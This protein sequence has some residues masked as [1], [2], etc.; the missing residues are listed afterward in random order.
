MKFT[1]KALVLL[2]AIPLLSAGFLTA[3]SGDD[4]TEVETITITWEIPDHA[5][6]TVEGYD[7][8]PTEV[9]SGTSLTFSVTCDSGYEV[10]SVTN[11]NKKVTASNGSY[12][13]TFSSSTTIAIN[14]S[15]VVSNIEVTS[16][17]T[18]LSYFSGESLDTTGMV[19][20]ATYADG[21][22][23]TIEKGSSGYA[24]SPS[25]FEGGE[26]SFSV[27]YNSFTIEVELDDQVE[28]LIN[29]DPNGGTIDQDWI[30]LLASKNLNNYAI[31]DDGVIT[32]SYYN[33]LGTGITLPTSEEITREYYS[34]INWGDYTTITN[35]TGSADISASWQIELVE[36]DKVYLESDNGT[37]Y[38]VVTG[39]YIAADEVQLVLYEGNKDI[40]LEGD[41]YTGEMGGE[42][43]C[44]FDLTKLKDK[45][46]EDSSYLGAWMDIRFAAV[47]DG[48]VEDMEIYVDSV[49]VDLDQKLILNGY[50]YTFAEWDGKLK[51]Y[52]SESAYTYTAEVEGTTLTISGYFDT[53]YA[54]NYPALSFW[55]GSETAVNYGS[56]IAADGSYSVSVDL[57]TIT[58]TGTN[59]YAHFWLES[60]NDGTGEVTYGTSASSDLLI[61]NCET[62]FSNAVSVGDVY[63]ANTYDI[64]GY[65]YYVGRGNASGLMLYIEDVSLVYDEVTLEMENGKVY[66]VVNG[67]YSSDVYTAADLAFSFDFQ[68]NSNLDSMGWDYIYQNTTA[69]AATVDETNGT[70]SWKLEVSSSDVLSYDNTNKWVLT[71][72]MQ[73]GDGSSGIADLKPKSI[74]SVSYNLSGVNY[75]L[76]MSS[77]T[78][79]CASLVMQP[80]SSADSDPSKTF[81]I[82]NPGIVEEDGKAVMQVN[83]TYEGYTQT[84]F[85]AVEFLFTLQENSSRDGLGTWNMAEI[86]PAMTANDDGT[87]VITADVTNLDVHSYMA[88]CNIASDI[89]IDYKTD[90]T[91]EESV[92]IGSKKYSV[93][94][95]PDQTDG[96]Y[97]WGCVTLDVE[98]V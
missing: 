85:S 26:T 54:G 28:H 56:A 42:F 33:N 34:F 72:H 36:I 10:T 30:D 35:S 51:V 23:E 66:F 93:V 84:E 79:N 11:N 95:Y 77:D 31:D 13:V 9:S 37:P 75:S 47:V 74:T 67:T 55:I 15:K 58:T 20:T 8:V 96:Y 48:D 18:K 17:P 29:I 88:K 97:S 43:D 80:T 76:Q 16:R 21:S 41:T 63:Y 40:T 4:T 68:H 49:T 94:S 69:V 52:V 60:T 59:G 12:T 65:R 90:D 7:T 82:G 78:W 73:R 81:T 91:V 24:V 22:T 45:A 3:C 32:F 2:T 89:A 92:T 61:S 62:S 44:K 5:S 98:S 64:N 71:A 83:G 6:V 50:S 38:L 87:Y 1:K 14:I 25:V 19:V 27:I 39:T 53:T 57:T 86:A 70:W 46:V